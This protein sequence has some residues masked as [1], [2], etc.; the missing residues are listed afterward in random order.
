MKLASAFTKQS[1]A[2]KTRE[3]TCFSPEADAKRQRIERS[4]PSIT[5]ERQLKH[6]APKEQVE[7]RCKIFNDPI[8]GSVELDELCLRIV[9]TPQYK[10]LHGLKQLGVCEHVSRV[11]ICSLALKTP[12]I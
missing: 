6:T 5:P 8:H 3:S 11:S 2:V 4:T 10:R 7:E 9:D 1:S 12:P